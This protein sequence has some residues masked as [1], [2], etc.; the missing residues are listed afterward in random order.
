MFCRS[1]GTENEENAKLCRG[2]GLPIVPESEKP[3]PAEE[4]VAESTTESAETESAEAADQPNY[5]QPNYD[6]PNYGQPNYGQPNYG[7]PNYGQPN[8]GQPNYGQ[9]NYGQPNYGQPYPVKSYSGGS[10]ACLVLGIISVVCCCTFLGGLG[11]G[12]AAII[13]YATEQKKVGKNGMLTAG[14]ILGIVGASLAVLSLVAFIVSGEFTLLID[15]IRQGNLSGYF[16]R[17]SN[18]YWS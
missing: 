6:Q 7:Q 11:C 17:L 1:C 2:C 12:I 13:V 9:P 3:H 4:T 16:Q 5:D 8:Y 15:A 10:I 18:P 14:L